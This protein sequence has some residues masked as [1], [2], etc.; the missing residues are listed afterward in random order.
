MKNKT[1]LVTGGAGYIG[2]TIVEKLLE[3]GYYVIVFDTFTF[4]K[5]IFEG[6]KNRKNLEFITGDI[7]NQRQV[8]TACKNV[9]A[10]IH[11][12]GIVGDLACSLNEGLARKIN[13]EGTRIVRDVSKKL[14]IEKFIFA[15][16]CSTYGITKRLVHEK[17]STKP[18]SLYAQTKI[19]SERDLLQETSPDFH[20][21]IL[22]FSTV[23]GHSR[24][25]R[26][27]L[28]AN[29]F[30]IKAFLEG[31]ITV[32]GGDQWRPFIHVKDIANAVATVLKAPKDKVDRQ[33]F[34]VG[35]DDSHI[36]IK[37]LA[38]L[39]KKIAKDKNVSITSTPNPSDKRDYRVSF[40]KI[41]EQLSFTRTITLEE[42]LSEIYSNLHRNVYSEKNIRS[43]L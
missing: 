41:R 9:D 7:C 32:N 20:P 11:L 29:L 21:T 15:S 30:T 10:I 17:S 25:Q 1:I 24:R 12:A 37:K 39:V 26:F 3:E 27:D 4:A 35:D 42:G 6:V 5:D 31:N 28:V 40:K 16:S 23:F 38:L 34:N 8:K 36:Q 18:L 43:L 22:R 13:I 14:P 33:I 2:S 19:Q